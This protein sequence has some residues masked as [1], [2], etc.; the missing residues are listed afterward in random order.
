MHVYMNV[1]MYMYIFIYIYIYTQHIIHIGW[2]GAVYEWIYECVYSVCM[3]I[4][5]VYIH[6][7]I[8]QHSYEYNIIS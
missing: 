4:W 2:G 8:I 1:Y 5:I 6:M 7:S 3:C